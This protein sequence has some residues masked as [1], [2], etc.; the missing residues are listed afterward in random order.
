MP[1][2]TTLPRPY[3]RAAMIGGALLNEPGFVRCSSLSPPTHIVLA[4]G[5]AVAKTFQSAETRRGLVWSRKVFSAEYQIALTPS[6]I[7][8]PLAIRSVYAYA[9]A[10]PVVLWNVCSGSWTSSQSMDASNGFRYA[11]VVGC[12]DRHKCV[13]RTTVRR[14]S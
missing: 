14:R 2:S 3:S 12:L 8:W 7:G 1:T 9:K 4:S 10:K 13:G 6:V 5:A 11:L